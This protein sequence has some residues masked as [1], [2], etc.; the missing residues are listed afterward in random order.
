VLAYRVSGGLV[1]RRIPG[2]PPMLLLDHVGAR[3]GKRRTNPLA[4]IEDGE[5]LVIVGSRGGAPAPP[6][7]VPQPG[8][9][10]GDDGQVA[11]RRTAV[12]ARVAT[13]AERTRLWPKVVATYGG[14]EGTSSARSE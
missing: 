9:S 12:R 8:G 14:F 6:G 5:D 13:E 3:S 10:P 7:L 2:L 4:Y 11:S 1:G